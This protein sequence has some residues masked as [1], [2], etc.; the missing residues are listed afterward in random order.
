LEITDAQAADQEPAAPDHAAIRQTIRAARKK[1]GRRRAA[2]IQ[3]QEYIGRYLDVGGTAVDDERSREPAVHRHRYP[4]DAT[5][6]RE[7]DLVARTRRGGD[8]GDEYDATEPGHRFPTRAGV[9]TR[10]HVFSPSMPR[11]RLDNR[12]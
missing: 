8:R 11:C 9:L 5:V 3:Q 2:R 6:T 1:A 4:V 7:R 10:R 12:G